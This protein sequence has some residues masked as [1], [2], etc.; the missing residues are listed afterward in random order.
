MESFCFLWL[1]EICSIDGVVLQ[2]FY[3]YMIFPDLWRFPNLT[4]N[5]MQTITLFSS[6]TANTRAREDATFLRMPIKACSK[7]Q[8]L[9]IYCRYRTPKWM[10]GFLSLLHFSPILYP[11]AE[12]MVSMRTVIRM[13]VISSS[14]LAMAMVSQVINAV[15]VGHLDIVAPGNI[16]T[17]GMEEWFFFY[18]FWP[19]K[20]TPKTSS[21]L[22]LTLF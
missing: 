7:C 6:E 22:D 20:P 2:F 13:M 19:P 14:S 8:F 15:P 21:G 16:L 5:K 10:D 18:A 9:E 11:K 3:R 1:V 12:T 4:N 17:G